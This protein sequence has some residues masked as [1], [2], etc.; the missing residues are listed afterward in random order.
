MCGHDP[1]M[2]SIEC[3][4]CQQEK[5]NGK[6]YL[7][8]IIKSNETEIEA[9]YAMKFSN[10]HRHSN[11]NIANDLKR[12][13]HSKMNISFLYSIDNSLPPRR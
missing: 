7:I 5:V 1:I 4:Y 3:G 9:C 13:F 8:A 2:S 10:C 6:I 11:S 12:E